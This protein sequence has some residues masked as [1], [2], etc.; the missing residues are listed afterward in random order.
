MGRR[1][2]R[3]AKHCIR[4]LILLPFLIVFFLAFSHSHGFSC[5][6]ILSLSISCAVTSVSLFFPSMAK[7]GPRVILGSVGF[8]Y[9]GTF[10]CRCSGYYEALALVGIFPFSGVHACPSSAV[11]HFARTYDHV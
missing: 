10:L 9:A 4:R 11:A 1:L 5:P 7:S 6:S 3:C 2:G 8:A